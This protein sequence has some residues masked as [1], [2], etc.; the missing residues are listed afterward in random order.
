MEEARNITYVPPMTEV[1]EVKPE[2]IVCASGGFTNYD[3]EDYE[4]W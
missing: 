3:K 2:G 4:V 1:V